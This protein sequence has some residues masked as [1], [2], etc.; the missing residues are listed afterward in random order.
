MGS[1]GSGR[2]DEGRRGE[3]WRGGVI[4]DDT[5]WGGND[6]REGVKG[7]KGVR[8]RVIDEET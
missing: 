8:V 1:R 2:G 5:C 3:V 7:V 4:G 6:G